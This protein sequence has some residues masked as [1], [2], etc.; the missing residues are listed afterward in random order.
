MAQLTAHTITSPLVPRNETGFDW[1]PPAQ[2]GIAVPVTDANVQER[3]DALMAAVAEK[4]QW[5]VC[6]CVVTG[7]D[8]DIQVMDVHCR[9]KSS[10][11]DGGGD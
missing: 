11:V 2:Q 6:P 8:C 7:R 9:R 10:C 4:A 3:A 1:E 5:Y